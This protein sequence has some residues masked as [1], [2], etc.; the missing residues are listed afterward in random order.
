MWPGQSLQRKPMVGGGQR[1]GGVKG[2]T[3]SK[4][5]KN[6]H[7]KDTLRWVNKDSSILLPFL[8]LPRFNFAKILHTMFITELSL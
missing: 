8:P 2:D 3:V 6:T 1:G 7:W 5:W 4:K